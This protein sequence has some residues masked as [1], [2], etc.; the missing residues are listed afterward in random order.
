MVNK[1]MKAQ[2]ALRLARQAARS[3]GYSISELPKRG[4]GSHRMFRVVAA[5]GKELA[6]FGLTDHS[7]DVSWSVLRNMEDGL[8]HL[9]GD[10]W[11]EK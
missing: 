8:A 9:F 2:A 3:K 10:T 4:K 11:M 6:R 5:D 1:R 7:Q